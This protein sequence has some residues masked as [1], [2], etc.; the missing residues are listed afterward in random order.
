MLDLRQAVKFAA[1]SGVPVEVIEKDYLI[2]LFLYYI[3]KDIFLQNLLIFRGGTA[4]RKIYFSEYRFSEDLDFLVGNSCDLK[5]IYN[6]CKDIICEIKKDYPVQVE[7][8]NNYEYEKHR[9]QMFINYNIIEEIVYIK[10]LKLDINF[11]SYIPA[12]GEKKILFLYDDFSDILNLKV[13]DVES[14]VCDKI[15]RI[16]DIMNEPR[17][18]YDLWYILKMDKINA[19]KIN[20]TFQRKYCC[21]III[22]N[23]LSELNK[24]IY[25]KN[26]QIRLKNQISNLPDYNI[27]K[28]ELKVLIMKK[29]YFLQS[30]L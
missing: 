16:L 23:L 25:E 28:N 22:S 21:D 6:K 13:Y 3:S 1:K 10:K 11:D 15:G 2:E 27:I 29:F 20:E 4:L 17:D 26:W 14:V 8:D 19:S 7:I 30:D 24:K 5:N 9:I 18:I 12:F